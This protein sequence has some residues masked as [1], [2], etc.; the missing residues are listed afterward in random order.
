M[1]FIVDS[2]ENDF[3]SRK[4]VNIGCTNYLVFLKPFVGIKELADGSKIRTFS[5]QTVQF[6]LQLIVTEL[7]E[8]DKR[9]AEEGPKA[10][11]EVL[12]VGSNC[13]YVGP[14][15]SYY[16]GLMTVSVL[17]KNSI[18][19]MIEFLPNNFSFESQINQFLNDTEGQYFVL[20]IAA[21]KIAVV[22]FSL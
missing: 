20:S 21:T 10:I 17:H 13:I 2:L 6:P 18:G 1:G 7:F 15:K 19:A 14:N 3:Y 22:L 12:D 16:G 8:E 5:P 11:A 9:F 4:A